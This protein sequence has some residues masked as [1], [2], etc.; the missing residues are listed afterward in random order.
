MILATLERKKIRVFSDFITSLAVFN[1][2]RVTDKRV[3]FSMRMLAC[4]NIRLSPNPNTELLQMRI[5]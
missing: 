1:P 3:C 2:D 4:S 5:N